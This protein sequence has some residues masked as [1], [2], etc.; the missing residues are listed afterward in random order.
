MNSHRV[1]TEKGWTEVV[2][3]DNYDFEKF[4]SATKI[5]Q[6]QFSFRLVEKLDD[7]YTLYWDFEKEEKR[8]TLHYNIYL[9][10]SLYS[11]RQINITKEENQEI[12][13]IGKNL[14]TFLQQSY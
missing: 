13:Q 4:Y 3:D 6:K 11:T 12:L 1:T 5:L 14:F 8:L 7:F 10:L 9:G 2:L